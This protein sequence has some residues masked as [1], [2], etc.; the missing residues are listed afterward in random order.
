EP[1]LVVEPWLTDE[2]LIV[3]AP[4]F[5][6]ALQAQARVSLKMLRETGWLLRE[7]G[8]G[9]REAVEHALLPHLHVL[10]SAG[11]F[12]NSEAIK[13]A[14]AAGLGVACLSRVLVS[15]LLALGKLVVLPTAL[16][17]LRRRFYIIHGRQKILSGRLQQFLQFCRNWTPA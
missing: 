16:P 2:L 7:T 12:S 4:H 1:G 5:S 10:Q 9:T 17:P 15:D 3:C 14:A 8:S 13:H 11:E 6:L